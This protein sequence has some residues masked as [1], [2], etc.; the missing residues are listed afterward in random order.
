MSNDTIIFQLATHFLPK[1]ALRLE[2]L[3]KTINQAC[4]E[5]HPVIHHYALK[6]V[7]EIINL[8]EKPELKSRFLKELMRIEHNVSKLNDASSVASHNIHHQILILTQ[9]IGLFGDKIHLD[10]FLQS[11]R[12][13]Q[14]IHSQDCEM[15]SP[16]LLLWLESDPA[17]RQADLQR[18]LNFLE[19]LNSTVGLYLELL[20]NTAEFNKIEML[21]G[22]YQRPLPP[23]TSCHLILL[24]MDKSFKIVPRMQLGHHGMSLRLCEVT[25]MREIR[26]T[27]ANI[28]LAICQI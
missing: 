25:T 14:S 18:W 20:R 4:E 13:M 11:I 15:Y 2:C 3:Y 10:P 27:N 7:M 26:E 16:Q 1:I 12:T 5:T 9:V 8:I 6:N 24:R 23:K 22:F 21:N 17:I 28:D 19:P